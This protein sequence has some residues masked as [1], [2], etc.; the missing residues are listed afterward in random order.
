[1]TEKKFDAREFLEF[2]REKPADEKYQ[3]W[4]SRRCALA[5][6]GF[7][8]IASSNLDDFG[9]P[10]EIYSAAI[11]PTPYTFGA[12]ADRVERALS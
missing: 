4:D 1:M 7:T 5:K 10:G 3:P 2:C 11:G 6:F 9:I 12:L 8:A